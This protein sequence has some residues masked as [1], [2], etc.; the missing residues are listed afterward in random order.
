MFECVTKCHSRKM[1]FGAASKRYSIERSPFQG[2]ERMN[3]R[4]FVAWV[5]ELLVNCFCLML[6]VLVA[7]D[8][9]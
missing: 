3:Y 2:F 4:P 9:L 7:L 8:N 5:H 6:T 1:A